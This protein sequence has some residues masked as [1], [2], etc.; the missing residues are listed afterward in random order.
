MGMRA[1]TTMSWVAV[2]AALVAC[3][4]GSGGGIPAG[5]TGPHSLPASDAGAPS[6]DAG[7]GSG[8]GVAGIYKSCAPDS[9]TETLTEAA[10]H[11][12]LGYPSTWKASTGS[13]SNQDAISRD[14]SYVPTG[15]STPTSTTVSVFAQW[16]E[17][18]TDA[19]DVQRMLNDMVSGFPPSTTVRRFTIGGAPAIAWWLEVAPGQAGC[20]GCT[21]DPGPDSVEIGVGASRGLA[22]LQVYATVRINAGDDVFCDV[23]AI[24]ASLAFTP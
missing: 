2:S 23:E 5:N 13:M 7:G 8:T 18:A 20:M 19:A 11:F 4:G 10:A 1:S 14:Y 16:G 22:I 15:A 21:A 24:E 17:T 12:S 6:D 3:S 9:L